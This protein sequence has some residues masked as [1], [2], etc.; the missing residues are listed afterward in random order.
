M[1]VKNKVITL[2][3]ALRLRE[4]GVNQIPSI[5]TYCWY[6]AAEASPIIIPSQWILEKPPISNSTEVISAFDTAELGIMLP[7]D[8]Q[9]SISRNKKNLWSV[10]YSNVLTPIRC[11]TEAQARGNALIQ[12]IELGYV[13]VTHV[14]M[15]LME[16]SN[17]EDVLIGLS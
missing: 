1:E 10:R 12:L 15:N 14:N 17:V 9:L 5:S 6:L 4:L 3:Q 11:E 16:V 8:S 7:S 13:N 2:P